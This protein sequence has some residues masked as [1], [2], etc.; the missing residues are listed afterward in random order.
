[1]LFYAAMVKL[2]ALSHEEIIVHGLFGSPLS[3][4]Q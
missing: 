1:M 4:L 3:S 2:S